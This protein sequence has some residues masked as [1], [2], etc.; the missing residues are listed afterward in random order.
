MPGENGKQ[1]STPFVPAKRVAEE[2]STKATYHA[3]GVETLRVEAELDGDDE[4]DQ[5]D[6]SDQNSKSDLHDLTS[7]PHGV[8]KLPDLF[9]RPKRRR[10]P[11]KGHKR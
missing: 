6:E 10:Q 11:S 2:Q 1:S 3:E 8:N 7:C 4:D 5:T 9:D